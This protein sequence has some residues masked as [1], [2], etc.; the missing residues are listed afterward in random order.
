MPRVMIADDESLSRQILR[1]RL[2]AQPTFEI[3]GEACDGAEAVEVAAS[4]RPDVA[5]LGGSMRRLDA[6]AVTRRI[7]QHTPGTEVLICSVDDSGQMIR[8]ALEAG[9]RG[10]VLKYEAKEIVRAVAAVAAHRVYFSS[11]AA[12]SIRREVLRRRRSK[13]RFG[14]TASRCDETCSSKGDLRAGTKMVKWL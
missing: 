4:T 11:I 2:E 13:G 3:V 10:Y 8:D 6:A 5:I 1:A 7:R 9:A 14:A 12:E